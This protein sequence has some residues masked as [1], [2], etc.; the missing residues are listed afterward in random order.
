[1]NYFLCPFL[2]FLVLFWGARLQT[3][4]LHTHLQWV[5]CHLVPNNLGQVLKG[6]ATN[7]TN[8]TQRSYVP[9][10]TGGGIFWTLKFADA[11]LAATFVV[12]H[13]QTANSSPST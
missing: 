12:K 3:I 10:V 13:M 5:S 2:F 9:V 8:P 11:A 4:P 7:P 1:L 6:W